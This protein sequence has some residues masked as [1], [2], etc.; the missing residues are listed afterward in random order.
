[1][2]CPEA[3]LACISGP[4]TLIENREDRVLIE[5]HNKGMNIW[6]L[7]LAYNDTLHRLK[8]MEDLCFMMDSEQGRTVSVRTALPSE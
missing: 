6:M 2:G 8:S 1:M 5:T 3:S 7:Y 4:Y